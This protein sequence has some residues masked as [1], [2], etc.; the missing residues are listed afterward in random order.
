MILLILSMYID[1]DIINDFLIDWYEYENKIV[2]I[3]YN[4]RYN[5]IGFSYYTSYYLYL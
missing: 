2:S 1:I 5:I 3:I 4:E